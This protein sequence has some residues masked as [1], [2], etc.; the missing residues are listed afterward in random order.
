LEVVEK[1]LAVKDDFVSYKAKW[2]K[3]NKFYFVKKMKNISNY[4]VEE[5]LNEI[6]FYKKLDS[7]VINPIRILKNN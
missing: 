4:I 6:E 5:I 2:S 3:N 1:I 7:K